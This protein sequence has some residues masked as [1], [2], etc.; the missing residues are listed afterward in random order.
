ML[1]HL[2]AHALGNLTPLL[3]GNLARLVWDRLRR[4]FPLAFAAS[5]MPE[6]LHVLDDAPDLE[7]ARR[8]LAAVLGGAARYGGQRGPQWLPVPEPTPV[9]GPAHLER[10]IRYV[11]LNPCRA[12]LCQD[13]LEWAWSTHRDVIGAAADPWISAGRLAR[14]LGQSPRNFAARHHAYVSADPTVAVAGT[15]APEPA[16][17]SS[18]ATLPLS[19]LAAAAAAATRA[20]LEAVRGRTA[21]RRLFVHLAIRD[22]WRDTRSIAA[23]CGISDRAVRLLRALP[24]D[25]GAVAAAALC[26]GDDRLLPTSVRA[27]SVTRKVETRWEAMCP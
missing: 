24:V 12:R 27:T 2:T 21:T 16:A 13:P 9:R 14:A 4:A 10:T 11:V 26:A 7:A 25:P 8:R 17:A 1:I 22:G 15:P 3:D 23:A 18:F 5:L 20:P 19:R 6:H